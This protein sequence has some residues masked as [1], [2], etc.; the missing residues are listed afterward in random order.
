MNVGSASVLSPAVLNR[1][2]DPFDSSSNKPMEK[3]DFL[4]CN[5][6]KTGQ[7]W[8]WEIMNML[9]TGSAAYIKGE[10]E[11]SWLDVRSME[12]I[13]EKH[14]RP[15]VLCTHQ[16]LRWLPTHFKYVHTC[17]ASLFGREVPWFY[18]LLPGNSQAPWFLPNFWYCFENFFALSPCDTSVSYLSHIKIC[19]FYYAIQRAIIEQLW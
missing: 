1:V 18:T 19:T 16:A 9:K 14:E 11:D 8:V 4:L 5:P 17:Q 10:K 7:H 3:G 12:E 13:Q 2:A 15:R 6:A